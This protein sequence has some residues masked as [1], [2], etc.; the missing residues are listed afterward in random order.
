CIRTIGKL[1]KHVLYFLDQVFPLTG[2]LSEALK[3]IEK[4]FVVDGVRT[5]C[6]DQYEECAL[7]LPKVL[8]KHASRSTARLQEQLGVIGV[9][10]RTI[11]LQGRERLARINGALRTVDILNGG[12][13][14]SVCRRNLQD[15]FVELCGTRRLHV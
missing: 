8:L 3:F 2:L 7:K 6:R 13:R 5:E 11:Q 1:R 4:S 10:V 9:M 14:L 15:L 12:A